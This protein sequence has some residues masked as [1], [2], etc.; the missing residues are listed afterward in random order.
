[1]QIYKRVILR[2]LIIFVL[3]LN[4][5]SFSKSNKKTYIVKEIL[6]FNKISYGL[7]IQDFLLDSIE[8]SKLYLNTKVIIN[9]SLICL[10]TVFNI[11]SIYFLGSF[12]LNVVEND[13]FYRDFGNGVVELD[14]KKQNYLISRRLLNILKLNNK[15]KE[16][17]LYSSKDSDNYNFLLLKVN[18]NLSYL[19]FSEANIIF[20]LKVNNSP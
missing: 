7:N 15:N 19:Y 6:N 8:L 5:V 20:K 16:I 3:L 10:P 14:N 13:I 4:F 2:F 11:D 17:K 18:T 9:D 1:M 12:Q